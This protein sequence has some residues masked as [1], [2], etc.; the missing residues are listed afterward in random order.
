MAYFGSPFGMQVYSFDLHPQVVQPTLRLSLSSSAP[1]IRIPVA[2]PTYGMAYCAPVAQPRAYITPRPSRANATH[3]E[4]RNVARSGTL[5]RKHARDQSYPYSA[6]TIV[7][8]DGCNA[9]ELNT[10]VHYGT[11]D[12]CTNCLNKFS[13]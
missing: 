10:F 9:I 11:L 3:S 4:L 13:S 1:V 7:Q 12:L 2:T 8:C 6:E 5:Y